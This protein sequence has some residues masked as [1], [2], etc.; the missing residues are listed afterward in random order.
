MNKKTIPL[1]E[2]R[3]KMDKII[4]KNLSIEDT[5]VLM[6]KKA[7]KYKIKETNNGE[8]KGRKK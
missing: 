7:S 3:K 1:A 6:L 5:L 8:K 4:G 2:Y